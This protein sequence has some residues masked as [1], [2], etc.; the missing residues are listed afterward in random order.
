MT[1][2]LEWMFNQS[3]AI[4]YRHKDS[5]LEVLLITSRKRKRWVIPKGIVEVPLT[6]QDSAAKEAWEEAGIT[7]QVSLTPVGTYQYQK[8]GG[9]CQVQ[10][11]LLQVEQILENWPE[12]ELRDRQWVSVEEAA[13]RVDEEQLKQM[14][15]ALPELLPEKKSTSEGEKHEGSR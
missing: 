1:Q 8:W 2:Q 9:T 6:S 5:E 11:Y 15:L 10:V 4:P 3:G 7:G 13:K 12:A 14:I